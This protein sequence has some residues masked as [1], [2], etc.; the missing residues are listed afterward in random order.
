MPGYIP[1]YMPGYDTTK[2]CQYLTLFHE[3]S[4]ANGTNAGYVLSEK[5]SLWKVLKQD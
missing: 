5:G 2:E 4:V 1:G 3:L